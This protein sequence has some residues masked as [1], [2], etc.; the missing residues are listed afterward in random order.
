M[1]KKNTLKSVVGVDTQGWPI[2]RDER[3]ETVELHPPH[4]LAGP[5]EDEHNLDLRRWKSRDLRILGWKD[6]FHRT[7]AD[8]ILGQLRTHEIRVFRQ[9]YA[10]LLDDYGSLCERRLHRYLRALVLDKQIVRHVL[11]DGFVGYVRAG[12]PIRLEEVHDW[13]ITAMHEACG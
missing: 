11:P 1:S 9:I 7:L 2:C 4:E 12:S 3:C 10:G 5:V 6:S 13:V 8:A